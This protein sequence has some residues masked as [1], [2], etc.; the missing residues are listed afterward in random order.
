MWH[1]PTG[2]LYLALKA[3]FAGQLYLALKAVFAG[4]D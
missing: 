2:Q 4:K 3:V 1:L